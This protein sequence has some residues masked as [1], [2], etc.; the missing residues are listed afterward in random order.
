MLS[1]GIGSVRYI[2]P[3]MS[4]MEAFDLNEYRSVPFLLKLH[5]HQ[6][7]REV[8]L[9]QRH[10][11]PLREPN[12]LRTRISCKRLVG[13]IRLSPLCSAERRKAIHA[14][15]TRKWLPRDLFDYD[16]T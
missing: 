14:E 8:R 10:R 6:D 2:L 9:Y 11:G 1:L 3:D 15:F 7:D 5:N 16:E 4:Y 13:S 12:C